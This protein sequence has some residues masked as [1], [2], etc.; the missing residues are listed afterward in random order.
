MTTYDK[1][2]KKYSDSMGEEGDIYH[3]TQ[4][5]PG[6]YKI[7]GDLKGKVIYDIG[8]GN[9][10]MARYFEKKGAR[11]YA[12]DVSRKMIK[13]AMSK[14]KGMDIAYSAHKATDFSRYKKESFDVVVMSMVIH[15]IKDLDELFKGIVKV[16]KLGG[17]FVFSNEH[18]FRPNY[19]YSEWVKGKLKGKDQLFIKVTDYLKS[20]VIK[21]TSWWG[22]TELIIH[23]R[24]LKEYVNKLSENNL[25]VFRVEE[26]ESKGFAKDFPKHLRE[27]HGIPT[28]III[29]AKKF[30]L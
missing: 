7:V 4:I 8:C 5:D 26:P 12:S 13:I 1:F 24:P 9:G 30:I 10:Y 25:Y 22:D 18:F 14:S 16:L 23:N 27:S 19:P 29:G 6:I 17:I 20:K 15:Y 21:V 3:R 28:F 11:V 2:A